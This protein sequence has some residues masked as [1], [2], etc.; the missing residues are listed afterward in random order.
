[1]LDVHGG[2]D[3][4]A[5]LPSAVLI[6]RG[7]DRIVCMSLGDQGLLRWYAGCCRTA[8]ANTPRNFKLAVVNVVH[9]CLERTPGEVQESFGR[10]DMRLNTQSARGRLPPLR[11]HKLYSLSRTIKALVLARLDGSYR[12]T[13][14]FDPD[15]GTPIS[16]PE[17]LSP[18]ERKRL[19]ER[20]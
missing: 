20:V 15:S 19:L 6:T 17:V 7:H 16:T 11:E 3:T 1:M 13:P 4:L 5:V 18:I 8:I 14:L 9:S 10:V 12:R 2:T